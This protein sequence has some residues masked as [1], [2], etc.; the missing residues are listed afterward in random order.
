M[1]LAEALTKVKD[2]KGKI[3]ELHRLTT[4]DSSFQLLDA[5]QVIPSIE[6]VLNQ[7][8][9]VLEELRFLK[10]RI[11]AAN[12]KHNLADK[13]HEMEQLRYAIKALEPLT[14]LKQETKSL[15]RLDYSSPPVPVMTVATFNVSDLT[16][17]LDNMRKRVRELDLEL[18]R[19]N[20]QVDV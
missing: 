8:S 19:L 12:V 9:E 1:K 15:Q 5:G 11:D 14:R 18:Q 4:A 7:L 13:I 2:I 10:T 3:A 16:S 6:P 20:W 17:K